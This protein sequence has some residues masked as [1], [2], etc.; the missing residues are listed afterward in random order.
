MK[1][2]F[3]LLVLLLVALPAC[4]TG[5]KSAAQAEAQASLFAQRQALAQ[6]QPPPPSVFVR[7][8]VKNRII[9]WNE[10]LTLAQAIVA[11]EYRGPWD[12]HSILIIR[13]GQTFKINPKHLLWG[14]E[15]PPLE[16]GD[17]VEI[18]R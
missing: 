18:Q 6:M 10:D 11:A 7:G 15:D 8:E 12:P 2:L 13:K 17:V 9:P 4:K 3:C 16:A 5:S 1:G 14:T